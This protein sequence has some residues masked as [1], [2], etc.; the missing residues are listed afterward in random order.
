VTRKRTISVVMTVKNDAAG[1]AETLASLTCQIRPPEEIIVVDGGSTDD[2]VPIIR[3]FQETCGS[4]RLLEAAGANIARGRNLGTQAALSEIVAT[5]DCGCRAESD[6]LKQ[7]AQPFEDHPATEFVAGFYRIAPQTLLEEVVGLATMRGQLEPVDPKA[8]NPSGR[9]MAYSK[10]LWEKAGGWPEWL[11]F[12]ED[13][14]FDRKLRTLGVAWH[15]CTDAIVWWRPRRTLRSIA[16]QFYNYG[17]GRGHTQIGAGGFAYNVRNVLIVS[18]A[19]GASL[20]NYW[21][22]PVLLFCL[23]YFFVWTFHHRAARVSRH[24]GRAA[25]YPLCLIVLA[26]VCLSSTVGYLIGSWQRWRDRERFERGI[27][28]YLAAAR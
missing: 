22:I 7:L 10:A 18:L 20:V 1:C 4:L 5:T 25:A 15:S 14:L 11:L 12:S 17:T 23:G 2:T 24:I 3:R 6:W 28:A 16:R 13:T 8:F 19:I 27:D 21:A 9:S 26:T